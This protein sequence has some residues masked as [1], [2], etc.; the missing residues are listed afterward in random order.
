MQRFMIVAL[1]A[2]AGIAAPALAQGTVTGPNAGA[3]PY[4]LPASNSSGVQFVSIA[5]TLS[6]QFYTNLDTGAQT[7]RMAGIPDGL[8][9]YRDADDIANNTF[10]VVQNHELGATAGAVRAHG[11]TGAFVSQ[12]KVRRNDFGVVGGRDLIQG[13]NTFNN[14]TNSFV[15]G[16][17]QLGRFCSGDL[18]AQSAYKWMDPSTG[19]VYGTD[20]RMFLGGEEIGAEGRAFASIID[21]PE[22][23]QTFQLPDLARFSWENAVSNPLSQRKTIVAGTDDST[24]GQVYFYVGDKQ[25]TGNTIER[26]GLM[27]GKTYGMRVP[28]IAFEGAAPINSSFTMVDKSATQR[29][30]GAAFQQSSRDLGVTEFAR[31]EDSAWNPS[32]PNQL[33]WV[34]TGGTVNGV[35]VP[36]RIYSATFS[37]ISNPET[38]GMITMLGQGNDFSTFGGG[39]TS[40]TPGTTTANSFDNIAMSRFNQVLIQEDVGNNAR[41]GRLWLY[42]LAQDSMLEIGIS[43]ASRFVAGGSQYLGT[44][45]EETSGIVDAWDTIGPGWWLLNMQAHYGIS[46]ELVEGGQ[47]MAVYIPQTV[48]TPGALALAGVAGVMAARRRRK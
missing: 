34:N 42:D 18:A 2:A 19:T 8:G 44:Q 6:D 26:A 41:L 31:P 36:T 13:V 1:V 22:A 10:S 9:I 33:I 29:G 38:G 45:D 37:D 21:G 15:A 17:Q 32:N 30:T 12:W 43:D 35:S 25:A 47:L 11:S 23:R 16:T 27:N 40:Y 7:Y 28:G 24:P 5:T 39:V 4:M 3:S 14:A 48:P 20:H 46:G